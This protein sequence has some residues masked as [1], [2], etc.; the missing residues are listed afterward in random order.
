MHDLNSNMQ[1][2]FPQEIST[3]TYYSTAFLTHET[4]HFRFFVGFL[5]VSPPFLATKNGIQQTSQVVGDDTAVLGLQLKHD[6]IKRAQTIAILKRAHTS[7]NE[8]MLWQVNLGIGGKV[9]YYCNT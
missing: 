8:S 3:A 9:Y 4:S 1:N 5:G 2:I 6:T 7:V